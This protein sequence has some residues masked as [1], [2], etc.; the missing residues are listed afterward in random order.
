MK[1]EFLAAQKAIDEAVLHRERR[2]DGAMS[3]I[4]IRDIKY[5]EPVELCCRH[6]VRTDRPRQLTEG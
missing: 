6:Y 1:E 4:R 3:M 5:I 2:D